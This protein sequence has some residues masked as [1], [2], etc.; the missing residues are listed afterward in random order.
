[1]RQIKPLLA[2][3]AISFGSLAMASGIKPVPTGSDARILRAQIHDMQV[4]NVPVAEGV[5]TTIELKRDKI[6]N[7]SM[8][9]RDAWHVSFDKDKLVMKP[10]GV[11]PDTNLTIYGEKRNYLFDLI[12][13]KNRKGAALWL[14][15]DGPDSDGPTAEELRIAKEKAD[16]KVVDDNLRNAR[17]EGQLNS[18]YWI[19]GPAELQPVSMHDNGRQT[20]MTFNAAN[21]MPAAY[22]IEKDGTESLVD[23]HVEGDTMVLHL[24]PS[25]VILRRGAMVAGITNKSP[26]TSAQQSPTGTASDKVNRVQKGSAK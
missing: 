5:S 2:A 25:K 20:Y 7:F 15:V 3:L 9:D 13:S 17:Y 18:N 14:Y 1:M 11:R 22:I 8:G 16:K 12:S 23:F 26:I 19:V 6:V 4:I 10:K 24:V 21:A